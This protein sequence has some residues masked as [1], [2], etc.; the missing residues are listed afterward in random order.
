[1]ADITQ[2]MAQMNIQQGANSDERKPLA[3]GK[4]KTPMQRAKEREDAIRREA[5]AKGLV[6]QPLI[7]TVDLLYIR[8]FC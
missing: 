6:S 5:E 3:A 8:S 1:M 7:L 2:S 4:Y